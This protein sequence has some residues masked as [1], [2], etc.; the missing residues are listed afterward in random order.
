MKEPIAEKDGK[1]Y[2]FGEDLPEEEEN[3]TIERIS[4]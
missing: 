3:E 4:Y 1:Y 2:F